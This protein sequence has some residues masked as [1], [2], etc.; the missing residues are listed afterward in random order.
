MD[1]NEW[2]VV[3]D[4]IEQSLE[5]YGIDWILHKRGNSYRDLVDDIMAGLFKVIY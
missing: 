3:K 4:S 1:N 2:I 5:Q